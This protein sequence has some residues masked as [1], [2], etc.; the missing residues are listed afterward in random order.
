MLADGSESA[1]LSDERA[2][3][4]TT[5]GSHAQPREQ[6]RRAWPVAGLAERR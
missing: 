6:L 3:A 1:A 4:S 5:V 2:R